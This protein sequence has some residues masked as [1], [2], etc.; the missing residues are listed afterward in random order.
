[1]CSDLYPVINKALINTLL[2]SS[3][4]DKGFVIKSIAILGRFNQGVDSF[5]SKER[6]Y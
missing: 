4:R 3:S 1:M 6:L 5:P 2:V